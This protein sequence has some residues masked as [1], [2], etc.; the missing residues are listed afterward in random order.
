[1]D[2]RN[3]EK[4]GTLDDPRGLVRFGKKSAIHSIIPNANSTHF[5][6]NPMAILMSG[7]S[8][9]LVVIQ[10]S[11]QTQMD[12]NSPNISVLTLLMP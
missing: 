12:R 5:Q 4:N 2:E 10:L 3:E 9:G 1:M 6:L 7:L 8:R 11:L